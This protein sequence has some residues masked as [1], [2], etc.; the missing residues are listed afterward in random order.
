MSEKSK[1]LKTIEEFI[2]DDN[3]Q[4]TLEKIKNSVM[5]FNILEITGMGSQEIKHSNIL[6]WMLSDSEHNLGYKILEGFLKKVIEVHEVDAATDFLKHYV[7]LPNNKRNITIYREKDNIDL[8]IVD[9][10]NK[11]IIA[12]ENKVYASERVAGKGGGQLK[13]YFGIVNDKYKDFKNKYFIYLTIDQSLPTT[14]ENQNIWL[15]ATHEMIGQVVEDVTK[16]QNLSSKTEIILTSYI[17]LLK[18]RNIMEDKNLEELCRKIWDT[19]S[20][21]LDILF[22]YRTTNLDK[23]YDLIIAKYSFYHEDYPDVQL[24]VIDKI[25]QHIYQRDWLES[26]NR[27][28][29]IQIN[30]KPSYIWIG[31]YHPEVTS[32]NNKL[33]I[34]LYKSIFDSK[35][36]KEKQILRLNES[37]VEDLSDEELKDKADEIVKKLNS[38]IDEFVIKVNRLIE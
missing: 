12:I 33:L 9:N 38:Q 16:S 11:V 3:V 19:N 23:L 17:D 25:Y 20:K 6:S 30:K 31:Y 28:I 36:Q 8:L 10:A 4:V 14:T 27:A 34:K 22:R 29:D 1:E 18:R 21:A 5:N 15:C 13:T 2:F 35:E 37:D 26:E 24:D 32:S 7:Y